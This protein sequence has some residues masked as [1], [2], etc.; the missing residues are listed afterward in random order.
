MAYLIIEGGKK[1]TGDLNNQ[2]AKNSALAIICAAAMI[3][4]Q[5]TI[6]DVPQIEEVERI[7]ELLVSIGIKVTKLKPG[8]L[9]IDSSSPLHLEKIDRHAS[10]VTRA[11]L[12]LLGAL[13]HREKKYKL[14]RSGGCKL[15]NRT[16]R[17]HLYALGKLGVKVHTA[18][19]YYEVENQPT[20]KGGTIIMY[21]SGDTA[22]SNAVMGAVLAKGRSV[23]KM[24]SANYQVQDLCHFLVKAGAKISGIGTTTLIID[25]VNKLHSVK[26]YPIMPDPIVAMT[27]ISTAIVTRSHITIKNCPLEFLELEL[28]KLQIMGQKMVI[29]NKHLSKSKAFELVDVEII[30]SKL[31]A[32][33]DK[34]ECRPFPG[35]NIDNL[36]LFIPILATARGRTMVHDWVYENRAIY[37]MELKKLGVNVDL[38]DTHRLWVEGPANF[39]PSEVDAPPALRPAV[40]VLIAMLAAKGRSV[41]HNTYPIDRGY[42]NLYET[43][44]KA[45]AKIEVINE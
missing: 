36:P 16:V 33:P 24:A 4:S 7:T 32:L 8:T 34:I 3:K 5:V 10:E 29:K 6:T 39:S 20:L 12:M 30:P 37:S 38:I 21:E 14:Y 44:K 45:G 25:G 23:I 41:L 27:F 2:S 28:Y 43:L 17:P 26:E 22:T 42:E 15:G 11:S 35:L 9:L 1:L 18:P 40:N 31:K 19:G 13:A